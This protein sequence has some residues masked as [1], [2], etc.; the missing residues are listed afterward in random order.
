MQKIKTLVASLLAIAGTGLMLSSCSSVS[1]GNKMPQSDADYGKTSV[2]ITLAGK[3]SGGSGVILRSSAAKSIILTNKHVCNLIQNGGVVN[4]DQG[5]YPVASFKVYPKHDLCL[6]EVIADLHMNTKLAERAPA[7]FDKIIVAG[8]PAL[9]PTL[10]TKGHFAKHMNID[11]IVGTEECDG[12]ET[13]ENA[14]YCMMIGVKPIVR[15]F[16]SQVTSALIMPGSSGSGV[17]NEKGEL[18]GLVFAGPGEGLGFGFIVPYEY[19][20]DFLKSAHGIK[21]E[22]PNPEAPKRNLFKQVSLIETICNSLKNKCGVK[23]HGITHD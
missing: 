12:S 13:E 11:L 18:A 8:H 1:V 5:T 14:F 19:V 7:E 22:R 9:L 23:S 4:N 10:I 17:F 6:V 20:A 3:R 16:E 15:S 21:A 2:S